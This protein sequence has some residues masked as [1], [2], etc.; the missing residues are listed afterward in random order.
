MSGRTLRVPLSRKFLQQRT[1]GLFHC[2]R[3]GSVTHVCQGN[4]QGIAEYIHKE[5][6]RG[7]AH[8]GSPPNNVRRGPAIKEKAGTLESEIVDKGG[9]HAILGALIEGERHKGARVLLRNLVGAAFGHVVCVPGKPKLLSR[10]CRVDRVTFI[11]FRKTTQNHLAGNRSGKS[12][13]Q[14]KQHNRN[15]EPL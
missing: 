6:W 14:H 1:A 7:P 4:A 15:L 5:I 3:H 2:A 10:R 12:T 9:P 11:R 8:V 13:L